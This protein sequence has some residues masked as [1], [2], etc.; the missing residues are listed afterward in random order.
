MSQQDNK[1]SNTGK[2]GEVG[3]RQA[4]GFAAGCASR[5]CTTSL[6]EGCGWFR[7][8]DARLQ[9]HSPRDGDHGLQERDSKGIGLP[10]TLVSTATTDWPP[11]DGMLLF[12]QC[13]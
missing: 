3:T 2:K 12:L 1:E 10:L 6:K 8:Q 4:S 9:G 11:L 13:L 7:A 5:T